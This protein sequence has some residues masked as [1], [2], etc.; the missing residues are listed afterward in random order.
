MQVFIFP[1]ALAW[2]FFKGHHL[3]CV[4]ANRKIL[5][6]FV[7]I[8]KYLEKAVKMSFK[9]NPCWHIVRL[10]PSNF[11]RCFSNETHGS[12]DCSRITKFWAKTTAHEHHRPLY[13]RS[14]LRT[15]NGS[16]RPPGIVFVSVNKY[17]FSNLT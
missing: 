15:Y 5:L 3:D 9:F 7:Y 17:T 6:N 2:T 14:F 4:Y 13:Y 10:M 16:F 8:N 1:S 11:Y 12:E